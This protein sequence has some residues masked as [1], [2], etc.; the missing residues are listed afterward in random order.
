MFQGLK[1]DDKLNFTKPEIDFEKLNAVVL[2]HAHLDHCGRL[3]ALLSYGFDGPVFMNEPTRAL[4]ELVL[5]DSARIA[6]EDGTET[7]Y[8]EDDVLKFIKKVVIVDYHSPFNIGDFRITL[9]DAGHIMGSSSILIEELETGKK[10]VFCGDLGNTPEPLLLPTENIKQAD[11]ALLE[12]TYGNEVHGAREESGRLAEI[13]QEA[14]RI[15]G[16]VMI[17]S[18]SIER[19]QEL[20]YVF[21]QLKKQG[22][23]S[24]TT[25][26]FLDSPMAIK[27]TEIFKDY[28]EFFSKKLKLQ[29]KTDDPFDFPGLVICDSAEKSK[30]IKNYPGVKVIIAGSGMMTGGRIIHHAINYLDDPKN[31]IVFVGFQ[32][33]G[34]LGRQ[35]KDGEKNVSIWGNHIEVRAKIVEIKSMS[36]HADQ[37][38]LMSWIKK[39]EGVEKVLIIHGEDI[40]RLV[41]KEKI[42]NELDNVEVVIPN[43]NTEIEL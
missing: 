35:I 7:L 34:T 6:M 43:L 12:S 13:V 5:M 16:T 21:D 27:A 24:S 18:F 15:G 23:V 1:D 2:T 41:L 28:P 9:Y 3:P 20:L 26:V 40:Q 37:E 36:S 14:E 11:F 30:Q 25:P 10:I 39:I 8:T 19:A 31:T 4:A 22:D 42:K 33:F 38:Q 17:P 32:A 29:I